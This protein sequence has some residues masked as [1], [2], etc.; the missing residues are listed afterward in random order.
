MN[1]EKEIEELR[2]RARRG[3]VRS[4]F[5]PETAPSVGFRVK[6]GEM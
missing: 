6:N 1:W 5:V 2:R 3:A 4:A